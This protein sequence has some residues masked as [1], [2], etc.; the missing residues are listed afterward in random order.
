MAYD[1][2]WIK[3]WE[4]GQEQLPLEKGIKCRICNTEMC[5][6][7][8][9]KLIHDWSATYHDEITCSQCKFSMIGD[10]VIPTNSAWR[11]AGVSHG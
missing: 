5:P 7:C 2:K 8:G 10:I 1:A 3:C 6:E 9:N 11:K 4:C